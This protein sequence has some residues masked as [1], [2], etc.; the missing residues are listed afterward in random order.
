MF[1][2]CWPSLDSRGLVLDSC[3]CAFAPAV[4]IA[5]LSCHNASP[6]V[7]CKPVQACTKRMKTHQTREPHR[8][9]WPGVDGSFASRVT[10]TLTPGDSSGPCAHDPGYLATRYTRLVD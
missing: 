2:I 7:L 1:L 5:A 10:K 6:Y 8:W 9:Y 3:M 4:M